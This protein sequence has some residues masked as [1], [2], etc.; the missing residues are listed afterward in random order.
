M[1]TCKSFFH[2]DLCIKDA[3]ILEDLTHYDVERYGLILICC[4][5][6]DRKAQRIYAA[7]NDIERAKKWLRWNENAMF[8][9]LHL[10]VPCY[11]L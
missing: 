9:D 6:G 7:T 11:N 4:Y 8:H 1:K 5:N 2:R 10:V 3:R